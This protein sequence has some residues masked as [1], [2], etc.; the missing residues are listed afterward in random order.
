MCVAPT[1][2][3]VQ[4]PPAPP[5]PPPNPAFYISVV[6]C[7]P[8]SF[9]RSQGQTVA[10]PNGTSV[11]TSISPPKVGQANSMENILYLVSQTH[12]CRIQKNCYHDYDCRGTEFSADCWKHQYERLIERSFM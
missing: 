11:N 10:P 5:P 1:Y 7:R 8:T 3:L 2:W 9:W 4:L 6:I 12:F